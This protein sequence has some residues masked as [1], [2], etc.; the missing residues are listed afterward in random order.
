[1][2]RERLD[3]RWLFSFLNSATAPTW[4]L[5]KWRIRGMITLINTE[6]S[7]PGSKN[8]WDSR[9]PW[10]GVYYSITDSHW[11]VQI[12]K[13]GAY[14]PATCRCARSGSFQSIS[15][16]CS[17]LATQYY[18]FPWTKDKFLFQALLS[19]PGGRAIRVTLCIALFQPVQLENPSADFDRDYLRN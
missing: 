17:W 2:K 9:N 1:M 5:W 7:N 8:G 13:N 14:C 3:E 12:V 18:S 15:D 6:I 19:G 4:K 11:G 16:A 10:P